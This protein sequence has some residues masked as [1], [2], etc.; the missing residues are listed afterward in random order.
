[1]DADELT[2]GIGDAVACT[3]WQD[4][5]TT[6]ATGAESVDGADPSVTASVQ[7]LALSIADAVDRH[8]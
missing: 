4:I 2:A 3:T 6:V 8:S 5:A 7:R 1:M